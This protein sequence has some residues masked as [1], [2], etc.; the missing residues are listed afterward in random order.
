MD[1]IGLKWIKLDQKDCMDGIGL[2]LTEGTKWTAKMFVFKTL[3]KN[4]D[5]VYNF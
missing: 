1:Q 3:K 5:G 2:K 4:L